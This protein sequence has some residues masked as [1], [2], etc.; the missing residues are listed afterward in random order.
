MFIP[1]YRG[2]WGTFKSG[3]PFFVLFFNAFFYA[4]SAKQAKKCENRRQK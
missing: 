2:E 1:H 4:N 3:V